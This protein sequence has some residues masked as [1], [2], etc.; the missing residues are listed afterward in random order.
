M[1]VSQ[2]IKMSTTLATV[3][4]TYNPA[5]AELEAQLR[6]LPSSSPKVIV[7]NASQTECWIEVEA[8][9]SQFQN[10]HLI[11]CD[12]NLGLAAAINQGVQ[13]LATLTPTPEFVLLLDQDS[14]PKPGS[15]TA[16]LEAFRSLKAKGYRVGCVGPLLEDPDTGLTHGF[17]QSTRW[18]W[19]RAYPATDSPLPVPCANLNGSGTLV[20]IALFEQLGGLDESLFID[21]VD[22]EWAF[23]V[24]AHGYS[25]WGIPKDGLK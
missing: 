20:P 7:D 12:T 11:R 5:L 1:T 17:H 15:I 10:V 22:T 25:L 21:H 8:L 16:L 2:N 24:T 4:V 13:W 3:T 9:V 14:E 18:R 19:T 6:A 23:R